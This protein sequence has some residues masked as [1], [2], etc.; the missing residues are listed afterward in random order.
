MATTHC[1]Q[2]IGEL[3]NEQ[4][5]WA[6][7][8]VGGTLSILNVIMTSIGLEK[9]QTQSRTKNGSGTAVQFAD[10]GEQELGSVG[11]H[12]EATP[13]VNNET[14]QKHKKRRKSR[15]ERKREPG[16]TRLSP[17]AISIDLEDDDSTPV[18]PHRRRKE[19]YEVEEPPRRNG[20][21]R[22]SGRHGRSSQG[23]V[24]RSSKRAQVVR[25]D[26]VREQE[27][28]ASGVRDRGILKRAGVAVAGEKGKAVKEREH[29]AKKKKKKK[30]E[31]QGRRGGSRVFVQV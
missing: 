29:R 13:D 6:V 23:D 17:D 10:T 19:D 9:V 12:V 30:K 18:V 20:E 21:G 31:R 3:M 8:L 28:T 2:T 22:T 25:E 1:D 15:D 16:V 24:K 7:L 27:K 11:E 26:R 4:N 14:I 5:L